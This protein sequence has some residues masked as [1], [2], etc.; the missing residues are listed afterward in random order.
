MGIGASFRAAG[1]EK[2]GY[3]GLDGK[4]LFWYKDGV[5][6]SIP[7]QKLENAVPLE[8]VSLSEITKNTRLIELEV[9]YR[10]NGVLKSTRLYAPSSKL[11]EVM[12]GLGYGG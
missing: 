3:T 9:R 6:Y 11:L 1:L 4:Y 7:G 10:E 2:L 5:L 12:D 8:I